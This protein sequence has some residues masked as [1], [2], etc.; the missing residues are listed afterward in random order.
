MPHMRFDLE[1]GG[2]KVCFDLKASDAERFAAFMRECTDALDERARLRAE[3][4]TLTES[5]DAAVG[6]T[7]RLSRQVAHYRAAAESTDGLRARVAGLESANAALRA[8]L[9]PWRPISECPDDFT[10]VWAFGMIIGFPVLR[11]VDGWIARADGRMS[12]W[13]LA[14]DFPLPNLER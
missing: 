8:G 13:M 10:K 9:L 4:A 12:R 11:R 6:E 2:P 14:S 7:A 1:D 5:R 3:N